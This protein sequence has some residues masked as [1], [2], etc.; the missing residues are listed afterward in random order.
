[1]FRKSLL[2]AVLMTVPAL[3]IAEGEPESFMIESMKVI[4]LEVGTGEEV[5]EGQIAAVHYTGWLYDKNADDK[6]GKKFDS[7]V[8]RGKPFRFPVGDGRVIRGWDLGVQGMKVG[9]KRQLI[10]PSDLGYGLRG[11]G[12]RIPP[13]AT[14]LFD[15]ELVDVE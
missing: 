7:S 3:L 8:G 6:K 11:A 2:T 9:G 1:M 12:N 5:S 15:V 13:G 4:E 14:L 10:I